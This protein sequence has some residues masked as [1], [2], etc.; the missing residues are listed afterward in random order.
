MHTGVDWAAPMGTPIFAAGNG[1][2]DEIGAEGRLRQI[3]A[4]PPRQRLRDRLR[5]H[6]RVRPRPRVGSRVRQGQVIGFVGSTGLSTG[7]HVHFEILINDRFVDPMT[8]KLPRGRV[9]DGVTLASSRRIARPAR[10]D[11]MARVARRASR[12][13]R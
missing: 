12:S 10:R 8:V 1:T 9:L 5:P 7:A 13:Q 11:V 4:H 6:D 3:R 2:I